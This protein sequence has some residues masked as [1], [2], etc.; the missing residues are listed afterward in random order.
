MK[1]LKWLLFTL[2]A[3]PTFTICVLTLIIVSYVFIFL[4][5][6]EGK[7]NL[8]HK[9]GDAVVEITANLTSW[10]SVMNYGNNRS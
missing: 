4:I 8:G 2:I 5:W 6:L 10:F 7:F 1:S 3:V 9:T